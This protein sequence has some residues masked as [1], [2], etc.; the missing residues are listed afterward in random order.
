MRETAAFKFESLPGWTFT[1]TRFITEE[2]DGLDSFTGGQRKAGD[3]RISFHRDGAPGAVVAW[4]E[5]PVGE[6]DPDKPYV[7]GGR[8]TFAF[9]SLPGH[10][11]W[12]TRS[13]REVTTRYPGREQVGENET[14]PEVWLHETSPE[15]WLRI[16]YTRDGEDEVELCGMQG[17]R[18]DGGFGVRRDEFGQPIRDSDQ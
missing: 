9:R 2:N 1:V 16:G 17:P 7:R 11:F 6:P 14:S 12:A 4:A 3:L 8:V 18:A 15:G 5:G 13:E 10:T